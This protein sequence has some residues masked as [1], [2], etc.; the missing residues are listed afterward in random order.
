V[1]FLCSLGYNVAELSSPIL[2]VLRERKARWCSL[3]REPRE[4]LALVTS[5]RIWVSW[6]RTSVVHNKRAELTAKSRTRTCWISSRWIT[7]QFVVALNHGFGKPQDR[8]EENRFVRHLSSV[9]SDLFLTKIINEVNISVKLEA[10]QFSLIRVCMYQM[11]V[12][13][14][15]YV[16]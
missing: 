7:C 13:F 10:W 6:E 9:G 15:P 8:S 16:E 14:Y 5:P 11:S 1:L 3:L 4:R 2:N 12:L